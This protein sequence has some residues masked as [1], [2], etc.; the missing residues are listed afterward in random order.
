MSRPSRIFGRSKAVRRR[1]PAQ[2][3]R[4]PLRCHARSACCCDDHW[5]CSPTFFVQLSAAEH[6]I[7]CTTG[8]FIRT[9][10]PNAY[11]KYDANVPRLWAVTPKL[12]I[13]A[14]A[15]VCALAPTRQ[16]A[17]IEAICASGVGAGEDCPAGE[18]Y[19]C[20]K[21]RLHHVM[22]VVSLRAS[23]DPSKMPPRTAEDSIA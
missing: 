13:W 19:S 1:P 7:H 16:G 10:A 11:R 6:R 8:I 18:R 12:G 15:E 4:R 9:S 22:N 3:L 2:G 23:T 17:T 21:Y 20:G 5:A 14:K